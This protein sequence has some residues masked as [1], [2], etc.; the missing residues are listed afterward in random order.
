MTAPVAQRRVRISRVAGRFLVFDIDDVVY[1]RRHHG[2]CAVLTGTMPQNPTQNLF[3]GLPVELQAEEAQLLVDKGVGYVA[4]ELSE[5]LSLLTSADDTARKAYLQ[6]LKQLRRNAQLVFEEE[7]AII[8][9]KHQAKR[10]VAAKPAK[11]AEGEPSSSS[12]KPATD[13]ESTSLPDTTCVIPKS[14]PK[15]SLPAIT[16][17]TSSALISVT[18]SAAATEPPVPS[19]SPSYLL[20][21][22]LNSRG[23]YFTPGLRFGG[24]W[25][26]YPGD[27]F[28]YHAHYLANYY[29]WNEEIPMLDLVTSGRLGTA[30]KKGFLFGAQKPSP[31]G[32]EVSDTPK[33]DSANQGGEVRVFCIEWAGM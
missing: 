31:A 27:P 17:T 2:I 26:V 18:P 9:A 10:K 13:S 21:R 6:H 19:S 7:K 1:I 3:L 33:Q 32:G 23:Y 25:S 8:Q 30:V 11:A 20:Y 14:P 24:D 12:T 15:E 29:G 5:H 16:P 22:F 4:D 28:R